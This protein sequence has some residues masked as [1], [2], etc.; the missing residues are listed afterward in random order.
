MSNTYHVMGFIYLG[1][2]ALNNI[3]LQLHLVVPSISL[4]YFVSQAANRN[5]L[6]NHHMYY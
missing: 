6:M 1:M 5:F 4:N 3:V 2:H